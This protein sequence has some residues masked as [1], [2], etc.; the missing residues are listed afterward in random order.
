MIYSL[1]CS[2][3]LSNHFFIP[4]LLPA[5]ANG[6]YCSSSPHSQQ[7]LKWQTEWSGWTNSEG[8]TKRKFLLDKCLKTHCQQPPPSLKEQCTQCRQI[9][10]EEMQSSSQKSSPRPFL[11]WALHRWTDRQTGVS[12]TSL[13]RLSLFIIPSSYVSNHNRI[14]TYTPS[15]SP[16]RS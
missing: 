8:N 15:L 12:L 11:L 5:V 6:G 14:C 3:L 9:F 13:S 10:Q 1:W 16:Q 7:W 2:A 4:W